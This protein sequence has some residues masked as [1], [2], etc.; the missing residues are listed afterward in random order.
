MRLWIVLIVLAMIA[1]PTPAHMQ[2]DEIPILF[3]DS[4]S[5]DL[6]QDVLDNFDNEQVGKFAVA[7]S[8]E[9][10][11]DQLC[12]GEAAI[13]ATLHPPE[14]NC[15][16]FVE[17]VVGLDGAAII[18]SE[19]V[20]FISCL[21][22]DEI[23]QVFGGTGDAAAARWNQVND[24]FPDRLVSVY[25][26]N[27]SPQTVAYFGNEVLGD[28]GQRNSVLNL[29]NTPER[30]INGRQSGIGYVPLGN[31]MADPLSYHGVPVNN[32][33]GCLLPEER[34]ITNGEFPLASPLYWYISLDNAFDQTLLGE[35]LAFVLSNE[36]RNTLVDAG[37][38]VPPIDISQRSLDNL[39]NQ[40][41]GFVF[42][43]AA[44]TAF[45]VQLSWNSGHDLD[46]RLILPDTQ[47]IGFYQPSLAGFYRIADSGNEYCSARAAS[48]HE[49]VFAP[50]DASSGVD[51]LAAVQLSL[52]C[53]EEG[54]SVEFTLSFIVDGEVIQEV[55]GSVSEENVFVT[56]F[57]FQ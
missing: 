42:S 22:I 47:E 6:A 29:S 1:I 44:G 26:P 9:I 40:R 4:L 45:E 28:I 55:E 31:Y 27:R 5:G 2:D 38:W 50:S 43:A 25:V 51:Y 24:N 34:A 54:E 35:L 30:T 48:P 13:L 36:G 32:G 52:D 8:E 49:S 17:V 37:A 46:L 10:S 20:D 19:G 41:R 14:G 7:P 53:N 39:L 33:D 18:A 56:P 12:N 23:Q 57:R 21:S 11:L 15:D 3:D 16:D